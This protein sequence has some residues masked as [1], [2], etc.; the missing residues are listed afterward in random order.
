VLQGANAVVVH[1]NPLGEQ[2]MAAP[3]TRVLGLAWASRRAKPLAAADGAL[4]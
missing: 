2:Q 4:R 1:P 3:A